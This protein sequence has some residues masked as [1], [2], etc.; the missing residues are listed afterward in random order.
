MSE[1]LELLD[2]DLINYS[3]HLIQI[4]SLDP[5]WLWCEAWCD[6]EMG[7]AAKII[8]L[9]RDPADGLYEDKLDKLKR[10]S[11]SLYQYIYLW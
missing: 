10:L 4:Y 11:P 5:S 8:D 7:V 6:Q 2:Q 9:C 1:T 3:Q